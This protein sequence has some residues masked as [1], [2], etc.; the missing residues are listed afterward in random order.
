[1]P[2]FNPGRLTLARKRRGLTKKAL[3]DL[4]GVST[5]ALTS[6]EAEAGEYHPAPTTISKLAEVLTFPESFFMAGD[7]EEFPLGATSFRALSKMTARQQD[8]A[9]TAGLLAFELSD[10]L[11]ARFELP[12]PNIP[13]LRDVD[14]HSAADL[15]RREWGLGELSIRNM[16]HLLEA[17]GVRVFS[18]VEECDSVEAFSTWRGDVPFIFLDTKKSAEH[19]RMDAA[20]ELGHLVL[21]WRHE[22]PRGRDAE[23]EAKAFASAFLMPEASIKANAPWNGS[24]KQCVLAK[25]HWDVAV[26]ALIYRMHEVGMLSDWSYRSL[27]IE[28]GQKGFRKKEPEGIERETSQVLGKVFNKLREEGISKAAVAHK[29]HLPTEEL[30]KLVFGLVLTRLQG[31]GDDAQSN[32]SE[33]PNLRL[34][35]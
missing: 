34:V 8:Q 12:T 33:P 29:L 2:S 6:Y 18:L 16:V 5:R 15:V 32:S 27:F 10:W 17:Q 11:E 35:R 13:R 30:N 31:G 28:L 3:A 9:T 22:S 7:V 19:G 24:L 25:R 20:H 26:S 4:V 23:Q 21:H 1:M 14:A